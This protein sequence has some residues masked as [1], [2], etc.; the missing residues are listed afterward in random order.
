MDSMSE[1]TSCDLEVNA[2]LPTRIPT[3]S[4]RPLGRKAPSSP[5][6]NNLVAMHEAV[7]NVALLQIQARYPQYRHLANS[8]PKDT[9]EQYVFQI[10]LQYYNSI[11]QKPLA[12]LSSM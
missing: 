6:S 11:V 3:A 12:V 8:M 7:Y 1:W 4:T 9:Q 2:P 5:P 10:P